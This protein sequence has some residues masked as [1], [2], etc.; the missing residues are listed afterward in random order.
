M[1]RLLETVTGKLIDPINPAA[2]QIDIEDIAW[3]LSRIARFCGHT[4]TVVPYSVAQHSVFVAKKVEELLNGG[5]DTLNEVQITDQA[6]DSW[7]I[8]PDDR[9]RL[10]LKALLHDAAEIYIGDL[11]SPIKRIPELRPIIK[12][13]ED[14]LFV[15]V[16][17]AFNLSEVDSEEEKL[18]KYADKLAQKIEAHAFMQ[19][20]GKHWEGLPDVSLE[21]LQKFETPLPSLDAYKLFK[22]TFDEYYKKVQR[23]N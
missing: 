12:Q 13:I 15:T 16:L 3:A 7:M 23:C 2:E 22:Q 8:D 19:S 18:I 11:P 10:V 5:V 17:N 20:R 21:E 9:Y 4:I 14:K 6:W 1:S